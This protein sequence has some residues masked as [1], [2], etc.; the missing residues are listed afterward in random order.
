[1]PE[2]ASE[3]IV[4]FAVEKIFQAVMDIES[5]PRTLSFVRKMTILE[6]DESFIIARVSV[7]LPMLNFC[8]DCRIEPEQNRSVKVTL[9]SGPFRRM[10]ALWT[11]E[12]LGPEQTKVVYALDTEFK[13]P[14]MEM[15]AGALFA[16]QIHQSIRAFEE[17]LKRA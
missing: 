2:I 1:M 16:S 7:G 6:K 3:R 17:R 13:N 14:L 4:P 12:A 11:F 8:Y 9:I 5:Y 10:N 15:T